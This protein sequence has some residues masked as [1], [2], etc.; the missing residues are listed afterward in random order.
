M[1]GKITSASSSIA[2]IT[3]SAARVAAGI[4][5]N[6][7]DVVIIFDE[8]WLTTISWYNKIDLQLR[9]EQETHDDQVCE[10]AK[11][12]LEAE[13]EKECLEQELAGAH[14]LTEA[15]NIQLFPLNLCPGCSSMMSENFS[16]LAWSNFCFHMVSLALRIKSSSAQT[17]FLSFF[18]SS[19]LPFFLSSF[20][21]FFLSFF[22]P[23]FLFQE[24]L[25]S[26]QNSIVDMLS[27]Q[28]CTI[29]VSLVHSGL[30]RDLGADTWAT[31]LE[32]GLEVHRMH[33]E[34]QDTRTRC[35]TLQQTMLGIFSVYI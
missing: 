2:F 21:P 31:K 27:D 15:Q 12:L 6:K 28:Y 25:V 9:V 20:L 19:F 4:Q 13:A 22:L 8:C 1:F 32:L 23:F 24:S 33:T 16:S 29:K 10:M 3:V 34:L 35:Q 5:L 14:L 7:S 17:F 26:C 18:L 11:Q 30:I